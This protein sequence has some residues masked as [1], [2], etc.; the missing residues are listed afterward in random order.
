MALLFVETM[1]PATDALVGSLCLMCSPSEGV[2]SLVVLLADADLTLDILLLVVVNLAAIG[3]S[4]QF[5]LLYYYSPVRENGRVVL[6]MVFG[7]PYYRSS[8][9]YSM[10]SVCPSVTFCIVAK[11]YVL[12]KKCLKE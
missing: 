3:L 12:A 6:P 11:R 8:L 1:Q 5:F 7:R 9:W 4:S 10:S 2:G